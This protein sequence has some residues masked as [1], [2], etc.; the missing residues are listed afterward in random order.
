MARDAGAGDLPAAPRLFPLSE[1]DLFS[2]F[3]GL[4]SSLSLPFVLQD[5]HPGGAS[6]SVATVARLHHKHPHFRYIK[7]DDARL[8]AKVAAV[9][10]A[11]NGG[12]GV[13]A[14]W[15]GVTLNN[16]GRIRRGTRSGLDRY[17]DASS[18]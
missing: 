3:D 4:L 5:F 9:R 18:G 8:A 17:P 6:L 1:D 11:T 16:R 2:Y 12:I 10:E 7:L 13:L 15:G 14:G